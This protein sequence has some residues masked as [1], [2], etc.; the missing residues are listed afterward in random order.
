MKSRLMCMVI[1]VIG[2]FACFSQEYTR[3]MQCNINYL[4]NDL[5][6]SN[7]SKHS[8]IGLSSSKTTSAG[9]TLPFFDDF[10]YADRSAYPSQ[11][12]WSDS[13]VYVNTGMPIAPLS[14]GVATFD[15]LNKK[16]FPY[17]PFANYTASGA[18]NADTLTSRPIN[19]KTIGSYTL[20]PLD[21]IA[22]IFYYQRTGRGDSPEVQDSL[23]LDFFKPTQ[24]IWEKRV[25][26]LRGNTTPNN[27]D[28]IFKRAFIWINDTAYLHEGFRFRLRNKAATNGNFDNWHVDYV[29]L[30]RNR[31]MLADTSWSDVSIG[32]VPSSFISY[33]SAMPWQQFAPNDMASKYSNFIRNN[34]TGTV[35]TTYSHEI[36]DKN[37]N[38]LHLSNFG[39]ANLSPFATGGWQ[40]YL[41]HKNPPISYTFQPT[42]FSDSTEFV[43]KHFMQASPLDISNYNDTVYQFQ[44]FRN[45]YAYDDGSSETG[46]YILGTGGRMVYRYQLN[47][48]DTLRALRIYFEPA[49]THSISNSYNFRINVFNQFGSVPG[50]LI[51]KDSLMKPS[52]STKGHNYT[53]E[54][55]L[56]TPLVLNAGTYF[57]GIQ[58]FIASGITV[59]FDRNYDY[60]KN[61]YF[62]SGSG[63]TQSSIKGS[64]LMRP[65]FGKAI[66][67]PVSILE[68]SRE[69]LGIRVF[70]NPANEYIQIVTEADSDKKLHFKIISPE[71]K[72]IK[73]DKLDTSATRVSIENFADGIYFLLI[74][75]VSG[76]I[77][78]RQ[79]VIIQH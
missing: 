64:V 71:G 43:I 21:S 72:M 10:Y 47:Y 36:F 48:T 59:G 32:Y 61:L 26:A 57:I 38:S 37:G 73:S 44:R 4:Y 2:S 52:Y 67:P 19:L 22:L 55:K 13:L 5:E 63:W 78:Q 60:S 11:A 6:M 34:G 23:M 15:G 18:S 56:T 54:Y 69:Q 79:K 42:P 8:V 29:Y 74:T 25:W 62:D 75:D 7:F 12:F 20:Q 70:P 24:K 65:V 9:I 39:A 40:N 28:T 77:I 16:G 27:T 33:C 58:Q 50:S 41:P 3:P 66:E 31:S 30:D 45:Y 53:A 68:N 17:T 51:Y 49:G 46:Y 14:I 35:N 1:L 76:N